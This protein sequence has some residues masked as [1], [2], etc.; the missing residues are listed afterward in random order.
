MI[1]FD[2][3]SIFWTIIF[4]VGGLSPVLGLSLFI[5][6]VD[7][8]KR[9]LTFIKLT[10]YTMGITYFLL[11]QLNSSLFIDNE[12]IL[13]YSIAISL[14]LHFLQIKN[15]DKNKEVLGLTLI[16]TYVFFQYWE[17][18]LFIMA[19]LGIPPFT[20]HGS[21]DQAY[22]ILVFY[23]ALRFTNKVIDKIDVFHL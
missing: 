13:L 15:P 5:L 9:L 6:D 18:P 1:R 3:I 4:I 10:F 14:F 16:V 8:K 19:H 7:I 20:Y 12:Q 11:G 17:V 21:I 23:I 22:L 2:F